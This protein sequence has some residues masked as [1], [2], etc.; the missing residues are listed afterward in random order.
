LFLHSL[1]LRF[2][3]IQ[4][5]DVNL[6]VIHRWF[7][8][9]RHESHRSVTYSQ[10]RLNLLTPRCP[11][12]ILLHPHQHHWLVAY[13]LAQPNNFSR[14]SRQFDTAMYKMHYR[15]ESLPT[16]DT[17]LQMFLVLRLAHLDRKSTRLNSSHVKISYA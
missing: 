7:A 1:T 13:A 8:L 17:L 10:V 5:H 2:H 16:R 9:P 15:P 14:Y 3:V 12:S 11:H 6:R 4:L